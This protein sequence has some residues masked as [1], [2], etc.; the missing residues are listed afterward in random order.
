MDTQRTGP[1]RIEGRG[2]FPTDGLYDTVLT[3]DLEFTYANGVKLIITDTGKNRHG[4]R[5]EGTDGWVFTRSRTAAEPTSLLR[6][7]FGPNETHLQASPGHVRNFIDCVKARAETIT[8]PEVAH[9]ATSTAL[10]GGIA[11]QLGRPLRWDPARERFIGD[12]DANRLLS[13]SMRSPW[14]V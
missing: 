12:N 5:F 10:L 14:R 1:V 9:R 8:P 7:K 13:Y 3:Y 6:E 2:V 11:V 4:V